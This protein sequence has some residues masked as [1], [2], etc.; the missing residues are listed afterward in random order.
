MMFFFL[1]AD[2]GG[3]IVGTCFCGG[4]SF[5]DGVDFAALTLE[6]LLRFFN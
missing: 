6:A 5:A 2:R 1:I 3:W 4:L